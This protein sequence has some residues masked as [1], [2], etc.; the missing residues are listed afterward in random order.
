MSLK[1]VSLSLFF[2]FFKIII[3]SLFLSVLG[4]LCCEGYSL[5]LGLLFSW[6]LVHRLLGVW[7]SVAAAY[8]LR[9]CGYRAW[10]PWG[11]WESS[12]IRDP[13]H[14]PGIGRWSLYHSATREVLQCLPKH[15]K[16]AVCSGKRCW[17]LNP[18]MTIFGYYDTYT[19]S[20]TQTK[21]IL[22]RQ[23]VKPHSSR[24]I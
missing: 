1:C 18:Q 23:A 17:D 14:V 21:L 13:T 12:Q 22:P 7:A 24:A 4:L 11:M 6:C 2:F 8:G 9:S 16:G 10:L 15:S 19:E 5:L 3:F 20:P